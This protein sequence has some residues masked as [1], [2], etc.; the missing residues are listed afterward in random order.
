MLPRFQPSE[1]LF[2]NAGEGSQQIRKILRLF[3]YRIR[4]FFG[5]GIEAVC[6]RLRGIV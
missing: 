2:Q 6:V 5:L 3:A 4:D 1:L